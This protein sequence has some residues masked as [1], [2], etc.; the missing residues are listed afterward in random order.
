MIHNATYMS[1]CCMTPN[2]DVTIAQLSVFLAVD[3]EKNIQ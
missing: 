3:V 1:V 2:T